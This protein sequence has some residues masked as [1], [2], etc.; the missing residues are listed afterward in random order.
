M[1]ASDALDRHFFGN[2]S[3]GGDI[4]S[5]YIQRWASHPQLEQLI[6]LIKDRCVS[7]H[8]RGLGSC[9][10]EGNLPSSVFPVPT[11]ARPWL[12]SHDDPAHQEWLESANRHTESWKRDMEE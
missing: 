4:V 6:T 9:L 2:L 8:F 12:R 11:T 10:K 1:G 7:C 3:E 5:L